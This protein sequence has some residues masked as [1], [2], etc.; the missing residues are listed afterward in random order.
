MATHRSI[1]GHRAERTPQ[2]PR[3]AAGPDTPK[4]KVRW[5]TAWEEARALIWARRGRLLLGLALMLINRLAGLVL[6][7]LS[8]YFVDDVLR[9][10]RIELLTTLAWAVGIA[11][12]VQAVTSFGL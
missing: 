7:G 10:G 2:H 4:K 9:L 3:P 11:T 12:V 8:K 6:P 1:G 5:S